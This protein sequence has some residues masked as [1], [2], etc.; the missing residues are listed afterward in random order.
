MA[1][2]E[3][4]Q[5]AALLQEE[6]NKERNARL[7]LERTRDALVQEFS[8]ANTHDEV[9]EVAQKGIKDLLPDAILQMGHLLQHA[10]S[11]SVRAG[12]SKYIT[13]SV[14]T[15]KIEGEGN[16]EI[17]NLLKELANNPSS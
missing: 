6:L 9:L 14:L 5:V 10:E 17:K 1:T 7:E 13:D 4:E 3:P 16:S 12:L 8:K 15:H 2:L 11:E